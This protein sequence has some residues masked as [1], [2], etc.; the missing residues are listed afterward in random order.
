MFD[1][2]S[3]PPGRSPSTPLSPSWRMWRPTTSM[4]CWSCCGASL[5][6]LSQSALW[7]CCPVPGVSCTP[8]FIFSLQPECNRFVEDFPRSEPG[9]FAFSWLV[10]IFGVWK[11]VSSW[12]S[13]NTTPR[14]MAF[15]ECSP[16]QF[17]WCHSEQNMYFLGWI[18]ELFHKDD[19]FW[20]RIEYTFGEIGRCTKKTLVKNWCST[21]IEVREAHPKRLINLYM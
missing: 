7:C 18:V 10:I 13:H 20:A 5:P 16:C 4:S 15:T 14:Y 17:K 2:S 6:H 8:V 12:V 3:F 9:I 1:P 19:P 11:H 21:T